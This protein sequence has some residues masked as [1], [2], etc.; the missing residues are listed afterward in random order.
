MSVFYAD[1]LILA[2]TLLCSNRTCT[3]LSA[4]LTR[5]VCC[6]LGRLTCF[7]NRMT[8]NLSKSFSCF[9]L[10]LCFL[11][12]AHVLDSIS[13][14]TLA[15]F[16]LPFSGPLPMARGSLGMTID[17]RETAERGV[18]WRGTT[19]DSFSEGPSTRTYTCK[20]VQVTA[21]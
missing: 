13:S 20:S 14:S 17:E 4:T 19:F 18:A 6:L 7:L 3:T 12:C 8:L 5:N 21:F 15:F 16:H 2:S 9:L 1:A 10:S 11:D